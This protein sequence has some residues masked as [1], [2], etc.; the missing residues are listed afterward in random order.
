MKNKLKYISWLLLQ[1]CTL[2]LTF[3]QET[4]EGI[5]YRLVLND[6]PV[7]NIYWLGEA[8]GTKD[9]YEM[10]FQLYKY[11]DSIKPINYIIVESGFLAAH[12]LNQY[13]CTGDTNKLNLCFNSNPG[14]FGWTKEH[15]LYYERIYESEK[16][17]SVK[18]RIKFVDID[19]EHGYWNTHKYLIDSII[20]KNIFDSTLTISRI[21]DAVKVG[22]EYASYYN[23]LYNDINSKENSYKDILG[24]NFETVKY[25]VR[26]ICFIKFCQS[27]PDKEWDKLRDSLIYENFRYKNLELKFAD[28]VSFAFWGNDHVLQA[29]SKNGTNFIASRIKKN[30]SEIKQTSYYTLY[31][32]CHFNTPTFFLPNFI[33]WLYGNKPYFITKG[34]NND[35]IWVKVNGTKYLRKKNN[36]EHNYPINIGQLPKN[37][38]FVYGRKTEKNNSEY[39]QY[40]ILIRKS[41]ACVPLRKI[42]VSR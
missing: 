9:N 23:E 28:K 30:N 3:C 29:E 27:K 4:Q 10:A 7:S 35:K 36:T 20:L 33:R 25:I 13:I 6:L 2:S 17:K 41:K 12:Y 11:I 1:L 34:M 5:P 22:N 14:T 42:K 32:N 18:D 16:N 19:I 37:L 40:V 15:K 38:D 26:N 21:H 24:K 39:I 31:S 8:H